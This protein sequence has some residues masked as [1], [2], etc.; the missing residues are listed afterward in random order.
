MIERYDRILPHAHGWA[1][2]AFD[3]SNDRFRER[4]IDQ[5][6]FRSR[7]RRDP[8]QESGAVACLLRSIQI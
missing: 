4:W 2:V 8:P 7:E 1:D 3:A 5:P 6:E